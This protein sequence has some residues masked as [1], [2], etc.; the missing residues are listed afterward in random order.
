MNNALKKA[1]S[2]RKIIKIYETDSIFGTRDT[3]IIYGYSHQSIYNRLNRKNGS[4]TNIFIFRK[5][6]WS[7]EESVLVEY[8]CQE[9]SW[10]SSG[11]S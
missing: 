3:T 6:I 2:I 5:K 7:I 8:Y 11:T 9:A 4:A 1:E 10:H